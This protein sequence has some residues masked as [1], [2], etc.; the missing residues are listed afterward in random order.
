M[1][2]PLDQSATWQPTDMLLSS[3][4]RSTSLL[5]AVTLISETALRTL[6]PPSSHSSE[7]WNLETDQTQQRRYSRQ[8]NEGP[9]TVPLEQ[10]HQM[11]LSVTNAGIRTRHIAN[12][13]STNDNK[14]TYTLSSSDKEA[15][16]KALI[17]GTNVPKTLWKKMSRKDQVAFCGKRRANCNGAPDNTS[18]ASPLPSQYNR[19]HHG[20]VLQDDQGNRYEVIPHPEPKDESSTSTISS[21]SSNLQRATQLVRHGQ[22]L[23]D[24]QVNH[25][26]AI[27]RPE[28]KDESNTSTISS[29]SSNL[30]CA[31]QLVKWT[32]NIVSYHLSSTVGNTL[33]LLSPPSTECR[34]RPPDHWQ[35]NQRECHGSHVGS[36]GQYWQACCKMSGFAND[37]VKSR[38]S[39]MQR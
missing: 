17:D 34:N 35:R 23:Q 31:T 1:D 8:L 11:Y 36:G 38:H 20:Q 2:Y 9:S 5:N 32:A 4:H 22:V 39:C 16:K 27:T 29:N 7:L 24:D 21:N 6:F 10:Q 30:Q 25:Y 14:K 19:A 3:S 12:Q 18:V 26:K 37:L 28:P 13:K 15:I 33:S